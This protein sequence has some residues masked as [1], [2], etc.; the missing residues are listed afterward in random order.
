[1]RVRFLLGTP[2]PWYT[3]KMKAVFVFFLVILVGGSFLFPAFSDA[4]KI[5]PCGGC[6]VDLN[7]AGQCPLD[8]KQ[9]ACGLCHIFQL[10]SNIIMFLLVPS[11][12]N[13]GAAP[14]LVAASVLFA[15]GGF[16]IFASDGNMARLEQGKK[17]ITATVIGLL[18]VYGSWLFINL[19]LQIM[20]VA[21]WKGFG[22]WWAITC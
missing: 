6:T 16:F 4:E 7:E 8:Q 5:I 15:L 19:L 2:F 21:G 20:G 3:K 18:I 22:T 13:G 11:A 17:I 9:P 1:M 14:V 12:F 10:I